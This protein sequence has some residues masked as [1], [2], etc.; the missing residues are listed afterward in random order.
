MSKSESPV[1]TEAADITMTRDEALA[2]FA[3]REKAVDDL[4]GMLVQVGLLKA[5]PA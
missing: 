2:L 1:C 4:T 3:R 5:K